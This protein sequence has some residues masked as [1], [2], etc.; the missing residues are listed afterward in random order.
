MIPEEWNRVKEHRSWGTEKK[1]TMCER[2]WL[3]TDDSGRMEQSKKE[4]RSWG[5]EKK[6]IMCK[7][8]WSEISGRACG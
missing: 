7:R 3:E 8:S 4:H 1:Q 5:T 6:Q 2:S